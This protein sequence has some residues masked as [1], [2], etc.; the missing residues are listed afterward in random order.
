LSCQ[1]FMRFGLIALLAAV[2]VPYACGAESNAPPPE[3]RT[4]QVKSIKFEGV[5]AFPVGELKKIL[6]TKEKRFRWFT[7]AP[8][9]DAQ[10][11]EDLERIEKFY[12]SRGFYHAKVVSHKVIPLG[13]DNVEVRIQIEEGP[14]MMVS[15]VSL[16]VEGESTGSWHDELLGL[17]PLKPGERFAIPTY[18]D[19]EKVV[20]NHL[21]D[22]GYPK[23]HVD[24]KATLNKNTNLAMVS[25]EA[26]KG[27]VCFFGSVRIEGNE[28]VADDVILRELTFKAG[29]RFSGTKIQESQQR[30]FGLDLFQLVDLTIEGMDGS[31]TTLPVRVLVREAKKQT[32]RVGAGYG[33]EDN[34]R[35]QVQYEVRDF[36]GDGRRLQ[37]NTKASSLIQFLEGKLLQP[38]LF[39]P[40][41]SLTLSGGVYH[42]D[43]ESFEN[44][45]I[46][47]SPVVNYKW[48]NKLT[49]Y[50][51]YSLEA[52]RLLDVDLQAVGQ[53]SPDHE[54]EEFFVSS[55]IEGTSWDRVDDL[56]NPKKGFR[57][58]EN[59]EWASSGFGS[60][61]DFIKLTLEGRGYLPLEKYGV[62]AARLKWGGI[63]Q[64][65][66]T[67]DIPI[68]KRFFSGGSESVRGYPY[69]RLGLLDDEGNPEGGLSLVEGS[70]EYR[71]PIREPFEGVTFVD[72]G[73]VFENSFDLALDD[74]R[75]TAGVGLRYL[76]PVG[77]IRFD[78]GYQLNPSDREEK[79]LNPYE[80]HFSIGQAF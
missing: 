7:K 61:V 33:T 24:L 73:N 71:F 69:Q 62:L 34:F 25:V 1:I 12:R 29:D 74:L 6:T 26:E 50:V 40:R 9:D 72:F 59:I 76:T 39:G 23:A 5:H 22:W 44:R 60:E 15:S 52:N 19:V 75:Y 58:I 38:Y 18:Q 46:L 31:S 28:S 45:K 65:E 53:S 63:H 8:L 16:R 20:L 4:R 80:F 27:P 42:E 77:P 3:E 11:N 70:V 57:L 51:G 41:T 78:V 43:Q 79:F 35:G 54:N 67:S 47:L 66:N 17:L 56:L 49:S 2:L 48:E 14:P 64:L 13:S 10:L 36:L 68:F 21:A 32:V 37:V 55:L 30:L